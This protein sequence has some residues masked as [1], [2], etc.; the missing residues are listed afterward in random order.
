M[1]P[2]INNIFKI[3]QR[4]TIKKTNQPTPLD[5][6][7]EYNNI[8]LKLI[9]VSKILPNNKKYDKTT[10]NKFFINKNDQMM[11]SYTN[12]NSNKQEIPFY[13]YPSIHINNNNNNK[14][15]KYH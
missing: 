4:T 14:N 12:Y 11:N 5:P 2:D 1:L 6:M 13:N 3:I 10:R 7:I 9:T 8:F 15:G